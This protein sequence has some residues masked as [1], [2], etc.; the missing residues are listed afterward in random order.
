MSAIRVIETLAR[1]DSAVGI[2]KGHIAE[3]VM[4]IHTGTRYI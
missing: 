3:F 2:A 1:N 4:D